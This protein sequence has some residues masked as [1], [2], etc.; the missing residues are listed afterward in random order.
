MGGLNKKLFH[1][2]FHSIN[3]N[4][5]LIKVINKHTILTIVYGY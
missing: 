2:Q 5:F 3:F 4:T 1:L